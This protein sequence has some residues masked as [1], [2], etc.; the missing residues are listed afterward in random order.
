M[1]F[2]NCNFEDV[3][4]GEVRKNTHLFQQTHLI[5]NTYLWRDPDFV[6]ICLA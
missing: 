2:N 6:E 1:R 3:N 4:T 5:L